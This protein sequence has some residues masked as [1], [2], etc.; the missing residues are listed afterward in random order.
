MDI[1]GSKPKEMDIIEG[2]YVLQWARDDDE[3]LEINM[4]PNQIILIIIY[5]TEQGT[6]K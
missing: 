2:A 4:E 3:K 6:N 5:E 1:S